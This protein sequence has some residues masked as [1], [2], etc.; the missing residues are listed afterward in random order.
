MPLDVL[1]A[2]G[3]DHDDYLYHWVAALQAYGL[4]RP[5]L[6]EQLTA[7]FDRT[8]PD[9]AV[10]AGRE[11]IRQVAHPPINVFYT[12]LGKDEAAF[13]ATLLEALELHRRYWTA[14]P[15][16][17]GDIDGHVPLGILAVACLAHD[18]GIPV[19]VESPY[20]PAH[21]LRRSRVG[22]DIVTEAG[23]GAGFAGGNG[24]TSVGGDREGA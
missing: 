12:F 24:R 10:I 4:K 22:G 13:H 20:L 11:Y 2:S 19:R 8:H 21:L 1:R 3:A 17:A 16:R 23:A 14:T 18:G 7:T 6:V 15:E 9:V 5:G